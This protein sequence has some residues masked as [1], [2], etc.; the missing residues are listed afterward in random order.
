VAIEN[1]EGTGDFATC[2]FQRLIWY[3][4]ERVNNLRPEEEQIHDKY[5]LSQIENL[6]V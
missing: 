3:N 5:F 6:E 1:L 2:N 4:T